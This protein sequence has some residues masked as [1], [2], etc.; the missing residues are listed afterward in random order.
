MSASTP[1]VGNGSL[2]GKG[3]YSMYVPSQTFVRVIDESQAAKFGRSF[4]DLY[5][6]SDFVNM[7]QILKVLNAV[8]FYEVGIPIT[9]AQ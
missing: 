4:L 1:Q 8:R 5:N 9:Y 3:S 6:P 7:G 2:I